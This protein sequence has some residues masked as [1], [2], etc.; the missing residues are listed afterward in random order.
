MSRDNVEIVRQ[1]ID[2]FNRGDADAIAALCDDELQFV[3][4]LTA[5]EGTYRTK[6]AGDA[7]F[8]RMRETWREWQIEDA[9][10]FEADDE[11]LVSVFRL[12]GRGRRSG[13]RV[14]QRM[15]MTYRLHTGESGE[16]VDTSTLAKL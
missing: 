14:E 7:Y 3:S 1:S 16:Y 5:V 13:A 6:D 8:N 4:F 15:G 11:N 9:E 2:A 12:V 10:I